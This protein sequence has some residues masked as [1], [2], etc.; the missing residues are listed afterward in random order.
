MNAY[1]W[2]LE[3]RRERLERRAERLAGESAATFQAANAA[4]AG[5]PPGQPILVGHHSERR[6]RADLKRH[7]D[8]MRKAFKLHDEAAAAARAAAGVG[9]GGISSDDP[10]AVNKLA[11]KRTELEV[12]RDE[13]K[14]ANAYYKKHGTLEGAP[15][16][17]ATIDEGL[18]TLRFQPYYSRPFPA[19]ALSN[20]GAR[21]REAARRAERI[22]ATNALERSEELVAGVT[23]IVDPEDNRIVVKFP[24]RL[25]KEA[26][27]VMRS[28]GW[29]WS[30]TRCGFVRKITGGA[31]HQARQLAQ[32]FGLESTSAELP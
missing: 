20:I 8:R 21:I 3:R 16:S 30:P 25:T 1:E 5:I 13:M 12:A 26:Y 18:R 24:S 10:D 32:R 17:R 11:D 15:V 28:H 6:H 9:T 19:Y 22:V 27:K 29:L 14:L 23:V 4:I 7:D 2:K 31:L